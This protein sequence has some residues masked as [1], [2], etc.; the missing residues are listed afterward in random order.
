MTDMNLLCYLPLSTPIWQ[1]GKGVVRSMKLGWF[2][3]WQ[4]D[5]Q[6]IGKQ[7]VR[8]KKWINSVIGTK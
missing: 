3:L 6:N 7:R 8:D 5:L 2:V 1:G 4:G